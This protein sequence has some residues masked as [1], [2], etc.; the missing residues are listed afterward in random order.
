MKSV[1]STLVLWCLLVF[2]R[3]FFPHFCLHIL[4]PMHPHDLQ[5]RT[6]ELSSSCSPSKPHHSSL[7]IFTSENGRLIIYFLSISWVIWVQDLVVIYRKS[8]MNDEC[9]AL[10]VW[11]KA[12][13]SS[14]ACQLFFG[15]PV[16]YSFEDSCRTFLKPTSLH[17]STGDAFKS[18]K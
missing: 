1:P 18:E 13:L 9:F 3:L 10:V 14:S 4:Q 17:A 7:R 5:W 16:V 8:S 6:G 15:L 2:L 11:P 12:V